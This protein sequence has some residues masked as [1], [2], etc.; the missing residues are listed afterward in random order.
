MGL[1]RLVSAALCGD[2][3]CPLAE[4][5]RAAVVAD[6]GLRGDAAPILLHVIAEAHPHR[7]HSGVVRGLIDVATGLRAD[8]DN[9]P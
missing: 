2:D 1:Y 4:R 6:G 5:G 7:L 8:D 3:G 9:L